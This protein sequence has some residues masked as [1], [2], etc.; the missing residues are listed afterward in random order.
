VDYPSSVV[1]AEHLGVYVDAPDWVCAVL[2]ESTRGVRS[3][4]PLDIAGASSKKSLAP[5][6]EVDFDAARVFILAEA[7]RGG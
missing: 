2:S 4:E 6:D 5:F 1:G 3:F 7:V